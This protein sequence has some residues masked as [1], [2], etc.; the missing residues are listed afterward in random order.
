MSA[1]IELRMLVET[2]AAYETPILEYRTR[3]L[4]LGK[5]PQ[6][7]VAQLFGQ[8]HQQSWMRGPGPVPGS[9]G[10]VLVLGEW[11]EWQAVPIVEA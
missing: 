11:S 2:S 7:S 4:T 6:A 5:K 10:P 1:L 9:D 8:Q 3:S